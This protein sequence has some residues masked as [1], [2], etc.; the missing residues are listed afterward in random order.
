MPS[1]QPSVD[2]AECAVLCCA[3]VD[4]GLPQ[5]L[6]DNSCNV[7]RSQAT[8]AST[9][10]RSRLAA[11]GWLSAARACPQ[12]RLGLQQ[13]WQHSLAAMLSRADGGPGVQRQI[14]MGARSGACG[15]G[16]WVSDGGAMSPAPPMA[17]L[18]S[19]ASDGAS[20]AL[21][22]GKGRRGQG[23]SGGGGAGGSSRSLRVAK[24][25]SQVR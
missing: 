24:E 16:S 6:S 15:A 17:L 9:C 4:T 7:A 1:R 13:H 8:S 25:R 18:T 14:T 3:V 10:C 11:C 19:A 23:G 2:R 21:L 12:R 20:V 5:P 22:T